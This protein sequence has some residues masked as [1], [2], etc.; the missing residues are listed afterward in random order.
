MDNDMGFQ[1][2]SMFY[3]YF[4]GFQQLWHFIYL[5]VFISIESVA[6]YVKG[7]TELHFC[8]N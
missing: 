5:V 6:A 8:V 4:E 3:S 1:P 7:F 2:H